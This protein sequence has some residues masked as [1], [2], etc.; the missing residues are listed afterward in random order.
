[1]SASPAPRARARMQRGASRA[2]TEYA[3]R[4]LPPS[5]LSHVECE[6]FAPRGTSFSVSRITSPRRRPAYNMH[7]TSARFRAVRTAAR[8]VRRN[9]R[10]V[11]RRRTRDGARQR[12]RALGRRNCPEGLNAVE[13]REAV[14]ERQD[15]SPI[16]TDGPVE[17]STASRPCDPFQARALGRPGSPRETSPRG[18]TSRRTVGTTV[19]SLHQ[20]YRRLPKPLHAPLR[21]R[22]LYRRQGAAAMQ[23]GTAGARSAMAHRLARKRS[24]R[25]SNHRSGAKPRAGVRS[26]R[27]RSARWAK[28]NVH[29]APS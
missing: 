18:S 9:M 5:R 4:S 27:N 22:A 17:E 28:K 6:S 15:G 20:R 26:R 29:L 1:M 7:P 11:S 13:D 19:A 21:H 3:I 12:A 16:R 8:A 24:Q 10:S 23:T 2:V 25:P 14:E